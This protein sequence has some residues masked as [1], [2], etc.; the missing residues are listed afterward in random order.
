RLLLVQLRLKPQP[1]RTQRGDRNRGR[2]LVAVR[3]HRMCNDLP[4]VADQACSVVY[5]GV[6]VQDLFPDSLGGQPD[7]MVWARLGG[8]VRDTGDHLAVAVE[9]QPGKDVPATILGLDPGTTAGT[10]VQSP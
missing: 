2:C 8:E 6:G 3:R 7:L 4:E 1:H 10:R 9:A 5:L